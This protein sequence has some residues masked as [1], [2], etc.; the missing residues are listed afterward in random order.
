MRTA[1]ASRGHGWRFARRSV[2]ILPFAKSLV[3]LLLF[4][5][6]AGA[7]GPALTENQIKAGF[8]FNFT[9][10]VDWPA[11]AFTAAESP[12]VLGIVGEDSFG[13]LLTQAAAGKTVN[14]R[15]VLVQRF[16]EEQNIRACNILFVSASEEKLMARIFERLS[17]SSV[18][19][20]GETR[21]FAQSG[22]I[23]N[24]VIEDNRVRLEINLGAA[25]RARVK[26]SAK[27]IGVARIVTDSVPGEKRA[28]ASF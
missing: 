7:E 4:C 9:R 26:I 1:E 14:G 6:S 17:G 2:L 24:F 23:I 18:L 8:L 13:D 3:L 15:T 28:S 27:V 10:F 21:G 19:T 22:G 12:I 11:D 20:V 25:A 16:K 5:L